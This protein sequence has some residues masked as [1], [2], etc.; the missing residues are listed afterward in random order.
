[1]YNF[2]IAIYAFAVR[3]VSPFSKKAKKMLI[4]QKETFAILKKKID[5]NSMYVWIHAASLGEFEQGRPLIERIKREKPEYKILLTFFSPSGYEVRKDYQEAD[6]V[7]YLPFDFRKNVTQFLNLTRPQIAIF[8][9]YE[10]WMN[11]LN[12]LRKRKIPTCI[13]STIFRPNQIFFRWYGRNYRQVLQNFD[14]FF[15]QDARSERLLKQL[16]IRD[17]TTVSGDTRFDRVYEI[18]QQNKDL[19]LIDKFLNKTENSKDFAL[20]AGSTWEKDEDILISYFNRHPEM[21]L[22]IAPHEF[23]KER[24]NQIISKITRPV[25]L[26]TQA[27]EEEIEKADCLIIDCFGLLSTIYRYGEIAY[28]GGGFGVG[29]HNVLEAAVYGIPVIFG[30]NYSK[31]KEAADLVQVGGATSISNEGK[32]SRRMTEF[33]TYANYK[34]ESGEKAGRYVFDNLGA[35]ERIFNKIFLPTQD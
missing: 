31:F 11:Y 15:L 12:Q 34:Q 27:S 23:N 4:G 20:V 2:A 1:M 26:Y 14:W 17:N 5:P 29:I 3:L 9:K 16:G 35:T 33:M 22:I 18:S 24:L 6:I 19:P 32:F 10:F 8:I 13:I 7:C 30:P 21:K 28:I 25:V